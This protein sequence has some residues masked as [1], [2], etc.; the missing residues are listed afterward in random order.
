[1]SH[2]C[3]VDLSR[4]DWMSVRQPLWDTHLEERLQYK[5]SV[6]IRDSCEPEYQVTALFSVILLTLFSLSLSLSLRCGIA[7]DCWM[8]PIHR[9]LLAAGVH[10]PL[11]FI[12]S[13]SFQ[14]AENVRKMM[15]F[16]H[17]PQHI[18]APACTILTLQLV[19][20]LHIIVT[21]T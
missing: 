19:A 10:Q 13:F 11:L 4:E 6:K 1:M 2:C 7:L 15:K 12:N 9:D 20:C 14:W 21:A 17:P 16:T 18:G 3:C 8:L 5:L